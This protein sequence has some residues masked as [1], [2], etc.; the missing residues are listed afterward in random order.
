[1]FQN[2]MLQILSLIATE[3]PIDFNEKFLRDEKVKVLRAIQRINPHETYNYTVRGQYIGYREEEGISTDSN[4]ATYALLKLY[5][6]NWRW[7]GVPF[8]LRSRKKLKE[9]ATFIA[10][11][12]KDI[13]HI[14]FPHSIRNQISPNISYLGIQPNEGIKFQF[15]VKKLYNPGVLFSSKF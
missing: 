8:Y 5:I 14:M 15:N 6:N 9:K 4:T 1:M 7:Q 10:I 3:P 2:H 11:R 13:P 12:F